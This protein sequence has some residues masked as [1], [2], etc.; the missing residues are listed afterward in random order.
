MFLRQRYKITALGRFSPS[1]SKILKLNKNLLSV[2]M[3]DEEEGY[4]PEPI[5]QPIIE[6]ETMGLITKKQAEDIAAFVTEVDME[7]ERGVDAL[8]YILNAIQRGETARQA[9]KGCELK[10][11]SKDE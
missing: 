6:E 4:Y 5:H 2:E 11:S 7:S 8:H 3:T 10:L 9:I 1:V